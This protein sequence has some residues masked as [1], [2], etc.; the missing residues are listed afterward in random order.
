MGCAASKP[1]LDPEGA[2]AKVDQKL[3]GAEPDDV[4]LDQRA[5]AAADVA[6][7]ESSDDSNPDESSDDA[8]LDEAIHKAM[9]SKSARSIVEAMQ[10]NISDPAVQQLAADALNDL[11]CA[12]KDNEIADADGI[13]ALLVAMQVHPDAEGVQLAVVTALANIAAGKKRNKA[14]PC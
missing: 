8:I 3:L 9:R 2:H 4:I 11:S 1:H 6:G 12:Y 14:S 13:K 5:D 7:R 10:A